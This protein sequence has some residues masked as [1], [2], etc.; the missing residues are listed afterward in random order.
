MNALRRALLGPLAAAALAAPSLCATEIVFVAD[1]SDD[2]IYRLEDLDLNGAFNDPGEVSV[3]YDNAIGSLP[4]SKPN[5]VVVAP[6]GTVFVADKDTKTVLA[7]RDMDHDGTALGAG[8]AWVFFDGNPGGNPAGIHMVAAF[9]L[10]LDDLGQVWVAASN[11]TS[12]GS[13]VGDDM[14]LVLEDIDHDGNA[15]G[16]GEARI[17]HSPALGSGGVG[18]SI[19]TA[20]KAGQDGAVY[21]SE[22]GVTGL[23]AKAVW[24]LEDLDLSGAIDQPG[25]ATV[26]F[27]IPTGASNVFLYDVEQGA[28]GAW[29]VSDRGNEVLW[30]AFDANAN[31]VIGAGEFTAW[32]TGTSP[33]DLW[34]VRF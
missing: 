12:S 9:G 28:D 16:V 21:Y 18:D 29:Y 17:F 23:L 1:T 32:F 8:E 11:L 20:V 2:R 5:G 27:P 19:P 7:L 33:S 24:R 4:M 26:F 3:F 31:G 10:T 15:N 22:N 6:D 13:I 30:R 34:T 14:I 25:E